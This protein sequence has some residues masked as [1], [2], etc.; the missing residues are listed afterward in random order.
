MW[1]EAVGGVVGCA[2]CLL[3]FMNGLL[4]NEDC[5][6]RIKK[7]PRYKQLVRA[8]KQTPA[9]KLSKDATRGQTQKI[10]KLK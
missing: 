7:I 4:N 2:N 8:G 10:T 1:T 3:V 9:K 6:E 5:Q